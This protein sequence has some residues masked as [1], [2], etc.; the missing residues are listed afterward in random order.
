MTYTF[1]EI[2]DCVALN[3][4]DSL[5]LEHVEP[6]RIYVN[7]SHAFVVQTSWNV[8]QTTAVMCI[9]DGSMMILT[10]IIN[11]TFVECGPAESVGSIQLL[12]GLGHYSDTITIEH[13]DVAKV[14]S[15]NPKTVTIPEYTNQFYRFVFCS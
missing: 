11:D 15:I 1:E 2:S 8:S 3:F 5:K 10:K 7:E 4:Y 13:L 12:D 6:A 14:R 9:A